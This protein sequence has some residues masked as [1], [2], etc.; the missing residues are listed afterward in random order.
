M[1]I[2]PYDKLKQ[3]KH[4]A[5]RDVMYRNLLMIKS[6]TERRTGIQDLSVR[7]KKSE[8]VYAR[9]LYA[10]ISVLLFGYP[11]NHTGKAIG[12]THA[13]VINNIKRLSGFIEAEAVPEG[14]IKFITEDEINELKSNLIKIKR[15]YFR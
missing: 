3:G 7:I 14:L 10:C 15:E 4:P 2:V 8:Y 1:N 9:Q 13:T 11:L 12:R 6:E 5:P